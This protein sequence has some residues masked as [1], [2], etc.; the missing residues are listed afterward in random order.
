MIRDSDV[1]LLI[2]EPTPVDT[3]KESVRLRRLL[4]GLGLPFDV[5]VM[6]TERFES[7]KDIID[8]LAYPA[9]KYGKT[10]YAAA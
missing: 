6:Q 10:I 1:D 2:L 8:G 4:R 9:K 7:T 5:F 3:R